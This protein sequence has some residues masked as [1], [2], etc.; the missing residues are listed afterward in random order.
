MTDSAILERR[1]RRL[2]AC[3]PRAFRRENEQEILGVLIA[4]AGEGRRRPGLAESADLIGNA[5][6]MRLRPG[7]PRSSR[8]AL[9]AVRLM[10]VGAAVEIAT[11]VTIVATIGNI[12][13]AI[14]QHDP[15]Y[16]VAQWHAELA[17]NIVPLEISAPIAAAVWLWLAWANGRGHGW[18]RLA[19][20]AFF[21]LTSVSLMSGLANGAVT[22][23]PA[24]ALAGTLLWLVALAVV[25]LIFVKPSSPHYGQAAIRQ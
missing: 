3:F 10:Y 4:G 21:A 9:A 24:D 12:H 13:A 2:L 16:T 18:A 14:L 25:V 8:T 1:Y 23:S 15:H 17:H 7:G 6:L 22:Y 20:A 5:L 11:L 19:F